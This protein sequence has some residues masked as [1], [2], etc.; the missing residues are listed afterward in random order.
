MD[1]PRIYDLCLSHKVCY[2]GWS[3]RPDDLL[4]GA[5]TLRPAD[6]TNAATQ[7]AN[8]NANPVDQIL[9]L[10]RRRRATFVSRLDELMR[11]RVEVSALHPHRSSQSAPLIW[12]TS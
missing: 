1:V 2:G 7:N 10:F 6:L 5:Q 12:P 9:E 11:K 8:H 3:G 4:S